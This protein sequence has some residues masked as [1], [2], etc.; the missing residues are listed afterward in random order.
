MH[1]I[2][3]ELSGQIDSKMRA[4]GALV[5][6]ADRAAARLERALAEARPPGVSGSASAQP[7]T[8]PP[9]EQPG[10][11]LEQPPGDAEWPA[12]APA[13]PVAARPATPAPSSGAPA[14][15]GQSGEP[16]GSEA[17]PTSGNLRDEVQMLS[18]YGYPPAEIARR[19]DVP[20]RE[21]ERLLADR[22]S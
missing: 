4:L 1:E 11:S 2:A 22:A 13:P 17:T 16:P 10:C 9:P 6:E 5:A 21:V 12:A 19:L 20:V 14:G 15:E 8:P 18:M 3:R 7:G